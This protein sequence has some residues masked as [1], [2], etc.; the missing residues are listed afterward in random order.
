MIEFKRPDGQAVK[1]YLAEP[2]DKVNAPGVV[3][4]QEWWGLDDEVKA[5]ADRLAKAGYRALVPDLYRG[6]LAIEANE[7][8]H[9]MGD[10]NFGD[11]ASQD[12]RGAVQY[13]KATG[14]VKVAVTGFCMG[15]ALTILAACNVPELDASIVWYGNPP[16][17]Y[18]NAEAINKPMLGHWAKHDE[19]FPIAGVD[20]LEQKL[21]QAG[22]NYEF[23]HYD[24]KHAFANPKSDARG[25]TPLK[26]N[27]EAAQLAWDR[28]LDFLQKTMNSEVL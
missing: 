14:S 24:T 22:V 4:I 27:A 25:L 16:L 12:I 21:K 9:L 19:F 26:Y 20:Q 7:A 3:V 13:L 8:E 18:V 28:T 10:L 1:G 11:A 15:G 5:V 6:K 2:E 17:E 23:H